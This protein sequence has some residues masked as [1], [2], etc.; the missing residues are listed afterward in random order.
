MNQFSLASECEYC[1]NG[2]S[3]DDQNF[4][5]YEDGVGNILRTCSR[6]GYQYWESSLNSGNPSEIA[7]THTVACHKCGLGTTNDTAADAV[8]VSGKVRR[9]CKTCRFT[10]LQS[11]KA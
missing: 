3:G 8:Y 10:W 6:C 11:K 9:T 5:R 2:G 1:G 7:Y 4:A